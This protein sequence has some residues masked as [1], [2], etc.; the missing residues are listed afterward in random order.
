MKSFTKPIVAALL[1]GLPFFTNHVSASPKSPVSDIVNKNDKNS[2]GKESFT[3]SL[4][5]INNSDKVR[6]TIHPLKTGAA[7]GALISAVAN[8]QPVG[9]GAGGGPPGGP[10][11]AAQP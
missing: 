3:I 1:A 6:L 11:G 7:G 9:N 4:N 2:E 8:G 10:S 5:Q